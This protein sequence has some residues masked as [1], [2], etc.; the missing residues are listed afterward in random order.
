VLLQ[1]CSIAFDNFLLDFMQF[2]VTVN[3]IFQICLLKITLLQTLLSW[4][5]LFGV[6]THCN[7][8]WSERK[9]LLVVMRPNRLDVNIKKPLNISQ[10]FIRPYAFYTRYEHVGS[11][12]NVSYFLLFKYSA[13]LRARTIIFPSFSVI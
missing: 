11:T 5:R 9:Q 3:F 2:I 13:R 7:I 12:G 6:F 8:D 4:Y 1:H 10:L